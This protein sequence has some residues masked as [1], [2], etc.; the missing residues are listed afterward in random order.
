MN[1]K[2]GQN[3]GKNGGIYQQ[4][5]PKGGPKGGPKPNYVT[6]PDNKPLPPTTTSGDGWKPLKITPNSKR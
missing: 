6:V 5:G 1:H 4:V 3:T 2:P